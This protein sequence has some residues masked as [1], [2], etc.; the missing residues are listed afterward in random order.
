MATATLPLPAEPDATLLTHWPPRVWAVL[1]YRSGDNTQIL[2]LAEALGWPFE[3][4]HLA[5]KQRKVA[6]NLLRG[7]GLAGIDIPQSSPLVPP[8]PDLIISAAFRNEPVCRWIQRQANH[9]VR[10][11]HIGRPWA[12]FDNFDLVITVPEY[13]LARHPKV[14]HNDL[15]IHGVT[16]ARLTEAAAQWAPR[17]VELPRPYIAVLVGG[18]SGPY[19]LDRPTAERLGRQAS[20]LAREF[21][22]S[23]LVTTSA[24]TPRS[25]AA[26]LQAAIDVPTYFFHWNRQVDDNPYYG[27]LALADSLIVTCDSVSMLTEACATR[28]PVYI[29]DLDERHT[30][31][32]SA[33]RHPGATRPSSLSWRNWR[34]HHLKA[35]LY[36]QVMRLP[37]PRLSRDIRLVHE[38]LIT[39]G[40]AVWLGQPFP[41]GPPLPPL[42]DT[43]R[44]VA[45]IRTLFK[46]ADG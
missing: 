15:S 37:I 31:G 40:R 29:F 11:V 5:Y 23:L 9:R 45:R 4:K 14:L 41:P 32:N 26:A 16:A 19:T 42:E 1:C 22:G 43:E 44:A 2:S 20:A 13:R 28:K 33:L 10:Y 25:S 38:Y 39:S 24:R 3:T 12:R 21:G 7:T 35:G 27:Y 30:A 34:F 18:Y 6:I 8:W 46:P 17:L 36:Q